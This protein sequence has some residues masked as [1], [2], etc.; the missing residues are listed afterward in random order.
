MNLRNC[1]HTTVWTLFLRHPAIAAVL[2]DPRG[3]RAITA[4]QPDRRDDKNIEKDSPFAEKESV[5]GSQCD[6]FTWCAKRITVDISNLGEKSVAHTIT[7]ISSNAAYIVQL[8]TKGKISASHAMK[9]LLKLSLESETV[10]DL[11][12]IGA[13]REKIDEMTEK[14][15]R[16][17]T[18]T[19]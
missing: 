11:D 18:V 7:T 15:N 4:T 10:R 13:A 14:M 1:K 5:I 3:T 6:I 8:V 16:H 17:K 2:R 12:S 9:I 19:N